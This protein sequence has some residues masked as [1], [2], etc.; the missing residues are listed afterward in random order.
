[1]NANNF[2]TLRGILG[3]RDVTSSEDLEAW[4]EVAATVRYR[5]EALE[6]NDRGRSWLDV[7]TL[8]MEWGEDR[9]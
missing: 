5:M 6:Y 3:G 1:M 9:A 7:L 8:V 2:R 4:T